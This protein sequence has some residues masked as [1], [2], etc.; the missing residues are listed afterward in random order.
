MLYNT[1]AAIFPG[2]KLPYDAPL[3]VESQPYPSQSSQARYHTSFEI[4]GDGD[5]SIKIAGSRSMGLLRCRT[6]VYLLYHTHTAPIKWEE[7]TEHRTRMLFTHKLGMAVRSVMMGED[8]DCG[9][10]LLQSDGGKLN[11]YYKVIPETQPDMLYIPRNRDGEFLLRFVALTDAYEQ[12][13]EK[14]KEKLTAGLQK[15]LSRSLVCDGYLDDRTGVLFACDFDMVRLMQ[16]RMGIEV[17]KMKGVVYCFDFQ[18][19]VLRRYFDAT[20]ALR[21][22]KAQQIAGLFGIPYGG[23]ST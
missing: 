4:K 12:L 18:A 13:K 15:D 11:R 14:L 20:V 3:E 22:I 9:L 19:D 8:M 6:G 1:G 2:T 16:F 10:T 21:T 7:M 23:K 5:E 17:R